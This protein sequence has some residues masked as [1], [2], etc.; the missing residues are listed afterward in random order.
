MKVY[1]L[2]S[3]KRKDRSMKKGLFLVIMILVGLGCKSPIPKDIIQPDQMGKILYDIHIVDGYVNTI[4]LPD[5]AKR[6]A[7]A[8]YKGVYKKFSVDSASY[9]KS[10]DFYYKH[11]D[12]MNT[13][14]LKLQTDLKDAKKKEDKIVA[15]SVSAAAKKLAKR[16]ADSLKTLPAAQKALKPVAAKDSIQ[17]KLPLLKPETKPKKKKKKKKSQIQST[18]K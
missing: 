1:R 18:L 13:I 12:I 16:K 15:D 17:R 2:L 6:V 14:Y 7:A 8:Y 11:P 4:P 10:L 5:S 9:N 3:R